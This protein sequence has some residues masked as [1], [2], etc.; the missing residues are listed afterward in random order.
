MLPY[1]VI[2]SFSMPMASF[3]MPLIGIVVVWMLI[4][5]LV[6]STLAILALKMMGRPTFAGGHGIAVAAPGGEEHDAAA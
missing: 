2:G 5:G 3:G 1:P 6:V 4:A